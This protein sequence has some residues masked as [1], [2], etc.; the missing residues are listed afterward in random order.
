MAALDVVKR[1]LDNI[2]I[3]DACLEL[4]SHKAN[5]RAVL[6]ELKRTLGLG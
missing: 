2:Q 5:K 4:H 6:D 1:R 3:G